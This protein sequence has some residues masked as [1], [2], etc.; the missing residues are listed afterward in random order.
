MYYRLARRIAGQRRSQLVA[1][2]L[3]IKESEWQGQETSRQTYNFDLCVINR[4]LEKQNRT[5]FDMQPIDWKRIVKKREWTYKT[6][7]RKISAVRTFLRLREITEHFMFD[8]ERPL[9][10]RKVPRRLKPWQRDKVLQAT[11]RQREILGIRNRAIIWTFWDLGIRKFEL[12]G[13]LL[14]DLDLDPEEPN[15][16]LLTKAAT[17]RNGK[18]L[19]RAYELKVYIHDEAVDAMK[20]WLTVRNQLADSETK[21]IFVSQIGGQPMTT[22]GITYLFSYLS[23]LVG[24]RLSAHDFRRGAGTDAVERG[25]PDRFVM[26]QLGLRTHAV[27]QQYTARARLSRYR[28]LMRGEA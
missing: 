1:R 24:F 5:I 16:Q 20:A 4:E 9:G 15:L 26:K 23:K 11:C 12:C 10:T 6:Q 22:A 27:F 2:T 18:Y 25:I 17:G 28:K 8:L 21:T 14:A 13:A 19:P 3:F 7:R